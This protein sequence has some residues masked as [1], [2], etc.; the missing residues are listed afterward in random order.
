MSTGGGGGK[1][2]D[3]LSM[4]KVSSEFSTSWWT[5]RVAL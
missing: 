3:A 1:E 5:E 2:K 4:Q